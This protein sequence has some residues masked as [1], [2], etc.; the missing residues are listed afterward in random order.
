MNETVRFFIGVALFIA[1][2]IYEWLKERVSK[3]TT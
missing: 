3:P 1:V 2:V